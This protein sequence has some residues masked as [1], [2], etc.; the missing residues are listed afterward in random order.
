MATNT[1]KRHSHNILI[2]PRIDPNS[3][4]QSYLLDDG[5]RNRFLIATRLRT[6]TKP[7]GEWQK[8]W[9]HC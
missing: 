2:G 6:L 9:S 7:G 5:L 8:L 1:V 4:P 3:V